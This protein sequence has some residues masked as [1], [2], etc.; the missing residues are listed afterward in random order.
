MSSPVTI[1]H[2][3][4]LAE[5]ALKHRLP[6]MRVSKCFSAGDAINASALFL[7]GG[8]RTLGFKADCVAH[9]RGTDS[10]A[11]VGVD[12]HLMSVEQFG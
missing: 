7:R 4:H 10:L 1:S 12:P 11:R 2:R 9:L 6:G 5:L 3:A 8:M